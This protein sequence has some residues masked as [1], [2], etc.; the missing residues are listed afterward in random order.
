MRHDS[1]DGDVGQSSWSGKKYL[2][3]YWLD[4]KIHGQQRKIPADSKFYRELHVCDFSEM[5]QKL[6]DGLQ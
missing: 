2:D 5:A 3:N 6:F 4:I 1:V